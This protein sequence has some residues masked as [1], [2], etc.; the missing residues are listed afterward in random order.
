MSKHREELEL[1]QQRLSMKGH[2]I[3]LQSP[4][5]TGLQGTP[6]EANATDSVAIVGMHGYFPGAMSVHEFWALLD[7]E[8]SVI[9]E[10]PT[11]RFSWKDY[12]DPSGNDISKMRTRWGGFIPVIDAFDPLFFKI[13]P[14]DAYLMDP[15]QRLLLMSV[16]KTIEDAGHAAGSL[17]RTRTGVYIG[18]EDQEYLQNLK[19]AGVDLGDNILNHHPSMLANRISYC[20][21]FHGPSEIV[22]TMCSSSAVAL[23]RASAALRAREIDIAIV[24]GAKIILRPDGFI[25]GSRLNIISDTSTVKSFGKDANGYV[26]AEGVATVM[27]KRLGDARRD[28]DHVYAAIVSSAINFN[29]AG[30]MSFVAPNPEAHAAVI[31]ECYASANIDPRDVEYI[32]AQGMGAQVSDIAEWDA[33]NRALQELCAQRNLTY[34]PGFCAVSTLKPMI[35]HMESASAMGALFKI[36]HSLKTKKLYKI[37]N[38]TE[39]NPYLETDGKPCR[40]LAQSEDWRTNGRPRLAGLHSYGSGGNNAHLLIGEVASQAEHPAPWSNRDAASCQPQ[41][42]LLSAKS[43][44]VLEQYAHDFAAFLAS[45]AATAVRLEDIAFTLQAGRDEMSC[46]LAVIASSREELRARMRSFLNTSGES[47]QQEGIFHGTVARKRAERVGAS[48]E[49]AILVWPL[50]D[51]DGMKVASLWVA[52]T[53][54]D[55]DKLHRGRELSRVSLPTYPFAQEHYWTPVDSHAKSLRQ[56][57]APPPVE[58][59][60]RQR[61]VAGTRAEAETPI[62]AVASPYIK[63]D[64]G[65]RRVVVV[66]AGPAG[67]ATAKCL[68]DEGFEPVVL[69]S[70]DRIGGIWAYR[71]NYVSGPYKSTLT[72][73]SKYT[74]FFSD[75]PPQESDP[76]FCDVNSVHAYL[77]RYIDYFRLRPR[78]ELNSSVLQVRPEG[79]GWKVTYYHPQEGIR[80]MTAVGVACCSGSF[81]QPTVPEFARKSVFSGLQI[82]ASAYHSNEIFSGKRVL[83]VGAGVSGADIASD[84]VGA[85]AKCTWSVREPR[86]FLP[87]MVGFVPNDCSVSF[88]KRFANQ[89]MDRTDFIA[90][91]RRALPE[92]MARYERTGLLPEAAINNA[93]LIS[94]R[95]I[96]HVSEGRITVRP[97]IAGFDG[98]RTVFS[99]GHS[100]EFD[101]IVYGTGYNKPAYEWLRPIRPE[102]FRRNLFYRDNPSLFICNHP[103]GIPAFGAAPPYFELLARWYAGVLSGR[104]RAPASDDSPPPAE[105][106]ETGAANFFDTWLESLRIAQEIGV[107]PDPRSD[108]SSYWKF[109]NMPPI[110]ALFRLHGHGAWAG[111]ESWIQSVRRKCFLGSDS[112]ETRDLKLA[113]LAGLQSHELDQLRCSGQISEQEFAATQRFRGRRLTPW[114]TMV[115]DAEGQGPVPVCTIAAA[116]SDRVA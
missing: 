25:A 37:L 95:I 13:A 57:G 42:F 50:S 79:S 32:E 93:I 114:L 33:Y 96:D 39:V 54:T 107:L 90:N 103:P 89:R 70:S 83:V 84:S 63:L 62:A 7:N 45:D 52:G 27:L 41:L 3:P 34:V 109:I 19:D 53:P 10:V 23:H 9:G 18:M 21:D 75:F 115:P 94:D 56:E 98:C 97:G 76:L 43:K 30:G 5:E 29:G 17:R 71:D 67:L 82:T 46:R 14:N 105:S 47:A 15:Q 88:L 48:N 1:L 86:W 20:F 36:V 61:D 68:Q 102:D 87:R 113:I 69:E 91:L 2:G 65:E 85:A 26:R 110:P 35:G 106:G 101:V 78:I 16:W 108:W 64:S 73:L 60:S 22:N 49:S 111:A 24:G 74:F 38:L 80:S 31:R 100:E 116:A 104:I 55:W 77:N 66:G 51:S 12:Y 112:P 28:R 81:W 59:I 40:L 6:C 99:D 92:Y 11:N 72:Q 58:K 4:V 8:Q 44:K